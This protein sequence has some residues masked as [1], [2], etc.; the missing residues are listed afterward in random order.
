MAELLDE[1]ERKRAA[2]YRWPRH[3]ERFTIGRALLRTLLGSYLDTAPDRLRFAYGPFGKPACDAPW[4][5]SGL[6]FSVS[7][8]H[9]LALYA[10]G[11]CEA[12]GVDLEQI[13]P[14]AD[15]E[16]MARRY[17]GPGEQRC[18]RELPMAERL[19]AFFAAW[20]R[21]E[22][23]LK[24][25]GTGL[26]FPLEKIAVTLA[27]D[28]PPRLLHLDCPERPAGECWL[29]AEEPAAGYRAALAVWGAPRAVER[30]LWTEGER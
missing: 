21:K 17:L 15:L 20:T 14:L 10:F 2:R 28:E 12:L 1:P 4:A 19:D 24:A 7:Y 11:R 5:E 27:P 3:G 9:A 13:R 23:V 25:L 18:W 6:Q 16:G 30:Y 29:A 8:S 26:S 22:A